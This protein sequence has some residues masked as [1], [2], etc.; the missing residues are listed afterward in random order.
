MKKIVLAKEYKKLL[1]DWN[2]I[3]KKMGLEEI[4]IVE[5]YGNKNFYDF[6]KRVALFVNIESNYDD[7]LIIKLLLEGV[8]TI[9]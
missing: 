4:K 3:N 8:L 5:D 9:E 7:E 2:Y 1:D 6:I